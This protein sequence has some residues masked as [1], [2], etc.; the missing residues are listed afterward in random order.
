[1]RVSHAAITPPIAPGPT[2]A[3]RAMV[4]RVVQR[5]RNVDAKNGHN[6]PKNIVAGSRPTC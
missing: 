6:Y 5:S 4:E 2:T 3:I 1:V